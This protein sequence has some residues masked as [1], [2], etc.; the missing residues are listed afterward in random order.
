[1]I[2]SGQALRYLPGIKKM[3]NAM[4]NIFAVASLAFL[5]SPSLHAI[6]IPIQDTTTPIK[7][8]VSE[9]YKCDV[10][11]QAFAKQ[12]N[13]DYTLMEGI[14][15]HDDNLWRGGK[16]MNFID[17]IK[18]VTDEYYNSMVQKGHLLDSRNE[19]M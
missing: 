7:V 17:M 6:G 4:R 14:I 11:G 12:D 9:N 13:G 5:F 2:L 3:D 18:Y 15:C 16:A 19:D 8:S 10:K 1:M